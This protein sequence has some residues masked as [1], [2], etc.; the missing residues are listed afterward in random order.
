MREALQPTGRASL[1]ADSGPLMQAPRSGTPEQYPSLLLH[2]KIRDAW[3]LDEPG[4]LIAGYADT[5]PG[6]DPDNLGSVSSAMAL[7]Y[8]ADRFS[9]VAFQA[10]NDFSAFSYDKFYTDI[11]GAPNDFVK[12]Q[13]RLAFWQPEM[14]TYA[15]ALTDY[16]NVSVYQP[17]FRNFNASHCLTVIDFSGTGIQELGI[18]DLGTVVDDT[19][20]RGA[21]VHAV[22]QDHRSDYFQ[23][24]SAAIKLFK[25]LSRIFG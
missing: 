4:G 8:P 1:I 25:L 20:N 16:A 2:N 9:F 22:E 21:T 11:S 23:P 13:K 3:G 5:L 17:F 10:D 12:R 15:A 19:L 6:F 14:A 24:L 18:A 7:L